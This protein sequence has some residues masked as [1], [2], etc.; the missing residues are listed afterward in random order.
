MSFIVF[1]KSLINYMK[2]CD[3]MKKVM[4]TETQ[5]KDLAKCLSHHY[6]YKTKEIY[7]VMLQTKS[8][9]ATINIVHHCCEMALRL[10]EG[11]YLFLKN[12]DTQHERN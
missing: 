3:K 12:K 10:E 2:G 5:L 7:R 1:N 11:V 8:I 6:P 9:D 4:L